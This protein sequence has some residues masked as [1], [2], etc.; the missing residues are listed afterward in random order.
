[1]LCVYYA[2]LTMQTPEC[3]DLPSMSKTM[4]RHH[5]I[6]SSS[7]FFLLL[8]SGL[9]NAGLYRQNMSSATI[10]WSACMKKDFMVSPCDCM[11]CKTPTVLRPSENLKKK[12][13]RV[14][15]HVY[16]ISVYL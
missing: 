14:K 4:S 15:D 7:F 3:C 10:G 16:S 2:E 6:V 9:N 13:M 1:M 12:T 8:P 11:A 5:D